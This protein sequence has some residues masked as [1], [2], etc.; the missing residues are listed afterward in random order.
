M[1]CHGTDPWH[2][3]GSVQTHP[4]PSLPSWL[5]PPVSAWL[6]QPANPAAAAGAAAPFSKLP[7]MP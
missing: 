6:A 3:G 4:A 2:G 1:E 5:L 7:Y